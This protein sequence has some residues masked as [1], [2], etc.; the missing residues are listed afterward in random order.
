M[1]FLVVNVFFDFACF[2]FTECSYIIHVTKL[3]WRF[4]ETR[5]G[6]QT[7]VSRNVRNLEDH[8]NH[9]RRHTKIDA[10]DTSGL[11]IISYHS[12][13][14]Y[15]KSNLLSSCVSYN[16]FRWPQEY[17]RSWRYRKCVI[18]GI[19]DSKIP[20]DI[21]AVLLF[22]N[23]TRYSSSKCIAERIGRYS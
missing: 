2:F 16:M 1:A 13:F 7:F 21:S 10:N 20:A 11:V 22:W 23:F 18:Y 6:Q 3:N 9:T 12:S 5:Q 19:V 15:S 17:G 8:P 4:L 14:T